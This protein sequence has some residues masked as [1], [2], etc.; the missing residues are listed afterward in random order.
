MSE[1]FPS[2]NLIILSRGGDQLLLL[3]VSVPLPEVDV[4]HRDAQER[5]DLLPRAGSARPFHDLRF[6]TILTVLPTLLIFS[7]SFYYFNSVVN[8]IV[9]S[10]MSKRW[11]PSPSWSR[12]TQ[13]PSPGSGEA[14]PT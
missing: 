7:G 8:P 1:R 12:P 10:L 6:G 4:R 2:R 5:L 14:F 3:L 13:N 11:V 9:Y